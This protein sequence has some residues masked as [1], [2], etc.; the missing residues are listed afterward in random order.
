MQVDPDH[1]CPDSPL[2]HLW[3]C[4]DIATP[5]EYE[6]YDEKDS[7]MF[8]PQSLFSLPIDHDVELPAVQ[9][10]KPE[11]K[12]KKRKVESGEW[13]LDVYPIADVATSTLQKR[14]WPEYAVAEEVQRV[15]SL[16][17]TMSQCVVDGVVTLV[18]DPEPLDKLYYLCMY[19]V[20]S[21]VIIDYVRFVLALRRMMQGDAYRL[22]QD[23]W[24]S[25]ALRLKNVDSDFEFWYVWL[26]MTRLGFEHNDLCSSMANNM[27]SVNAVG[28]SLFEKI[29]VWN[30]KLLAKWDREPSFY[31]REYKAHEELHIMNDI[32][33]RC[34]HCA[35]IV[36][37]VWLHQQACR[38]AVAKDKNKERVDMSKPKMPVVD[39]HFVPFEFPG[40]REDV[41]TSMS[42]A[43]NTTKHNPLLTWDWSLFDVNGDE[44][45][46][47]LT[48]PFRFHA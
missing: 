28:S 16:F 24:S 33:W 34:Q 32:R 17:H 20:R 27:V 36:K 26:V 38:Q 29:T 19:G 37:K 45:T 14:N 2:H 11:P 3:K 46:Q 39:M 43:H 48:E 21:I 9:G 18:L 4:D 23:I 8:A 13:S 25:K 7:T 47:W 5:V 30:F 40:P 42:M 12:S 15:E 44:Q 41:S 6:V 35:R 22:G 1:V 31:Y 10:S